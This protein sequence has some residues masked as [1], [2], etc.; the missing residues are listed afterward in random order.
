MDY[1]E[2]YVNGARIIEADIEASNGIIHVIDT[3]LGQPLEPNEGVPLQ[4]SA[5]GYIY[6]TA[7]EDTSELLGTK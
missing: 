6:E 7:E 3:F 4:N 1:Q 5:L 2:L